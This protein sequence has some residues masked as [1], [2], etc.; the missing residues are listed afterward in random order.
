MLNKFRRFIINFTYF[1]HSKKNWLL[2]KMFHCK[3]IVSN[4]FTN[5]DKIPG[6][7]SIIVSYRMK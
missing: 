7:Q 2:T 1:Q 6:R 3:L 5:S 4:I